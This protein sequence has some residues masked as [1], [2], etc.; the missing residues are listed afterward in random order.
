M[1]Y[2]LPHYKLNSSTINIIHKKLNYYQVIIK[3]QYYIIYAVTRIR[4]EKHSIST[5]IQPTINFNITT[6]VSW[7]L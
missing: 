2:N 6:Q 3:N 5:Y 7:Y 1:F 4:C